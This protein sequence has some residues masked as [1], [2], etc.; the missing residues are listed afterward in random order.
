MYAVINYIDYR[1]NVEFEIDMV[2]SNKEEAIKVALH[3]AN[4]QLNNLLRID[5]KFE[6]KISINNKSDSEYVMCCNKTIVEYKI[7]YIL[8]GSF[9]SNSE[10]V[11]AVVEIENKEIDWSQKI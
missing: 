11:H 7:S 1:K 10:L 3:Y 6:Y 8:N 5:R 4:I 9:L 2:T